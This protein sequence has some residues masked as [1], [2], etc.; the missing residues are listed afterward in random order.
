[1][2]RLKISCDSVVKKKWNFI[3][4]NTAFQL[5]INLVRNNHLPSWYII[6][7]MYAIGGRIALLVVILKSLIQLKSK[8]CY[9][10]IFYDRSAFSTK[11]FLNRW[12]LKKRDFLR[13]FSQIFAIFKNVEFTSAGWSVT[14]SDN[15]PKFWCYLMQ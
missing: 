11:H 7:I 14:Q 8:A 10:S 9:Y 2:H 3:D 15:G 4:F 12:A 6:I 13:E 5:G 1:M